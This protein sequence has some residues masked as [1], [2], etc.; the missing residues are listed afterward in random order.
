MRLYLANAAEQS[1]SVEDQYAVWSA[2][3]N[4]ELVE[5]YHDWDRRCLVVLHGRTIRHF[6][7]DGTFRD[8]LR[9]LLSGMFHKSPIPEMS[10]ETFRSFRIRNI[11]RESLT[12]SA[13]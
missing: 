2:F 12:G 10:A 3:L 7:D 5:N 8:S 6:G 11:W 13:H 4:S 1:R 9:A